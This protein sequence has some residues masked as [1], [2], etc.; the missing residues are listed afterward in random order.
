MSS[1]AFLKC[2]K[3]PQKYRLSGEIPFYTDLETGQLVYPTVPVPLELHSRIEG[4]RNDEFCKICNKYV[5]VLRYKKDQI[6][7]PCPFCNQKSF[8]ND[9]DICPLCKEGVIK[10]D[11]SKMVFF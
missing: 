6:V 9:G 5:E 4:C 8:I 1:L 3:C 2:N 11:M 7:T 10:I